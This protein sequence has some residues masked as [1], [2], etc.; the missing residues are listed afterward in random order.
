MSAQLDALVFDLGGVLVEIDF[1]RVI[2][3]WAR[4]AKVAEERVAA[5]F[6]P[7]EAYC[8]HERGELSE[9]EYFASLRKSL[10]I[11]LSDEQF[12]AGWNAVFGDPIPGMEPIVR[13]L[14]DRFPL[15]AFSNT[16]KAHY[17]FWEPRY[18][19]LLAPFREILCSCD[20]GCRK[21]DPD[22]FLRVASRIGVPSQRNIDL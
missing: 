10:A 11:D 16:N 15:Y 17:A 6:G 18:R 5:R 19:A 7:D 4:A 2:A 3:H 20:L 21:P 13:A 12:L 22:A 8:A 1:R 9:A 14:A